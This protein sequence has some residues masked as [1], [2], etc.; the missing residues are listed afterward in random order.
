MGQCL[1]TKTL[2][3]LNMG[4]S[5]EKFGTSPI[6]IRGMSRSGGTLLTSM[7]DAHPNVAMSYELYP[8]LLKISPNDNN[9]FLKIA[10]RIEK[11]DSL[12]S[13]SKEIPVDGFR[14][15]V[16]R[17][18]RSG[19]D[20]WDIAK[21]IKAHIQVG[22]NFSEYTGRLRFIARCCRKKMLRCKKKNWGV[23]CSSQFEKYYKVWPNAGFVNIIRD[24]RDV[25]ASQLNT[26]SFNLSPAEFGKRWAQNHLEF[27]RLMKINNV[28][29]VEVFY[30]RL[31][32]DPESA[33]RNLCNSLNME[34]NSDMVRFHEKDMTLFR[35]PVGH[36]SYTKLI[37]GINDNSI[38]RWKYELS[39]QDL[40][41][42]FKTAGE[43][44]REFDYIK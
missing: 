43:A 40:N 23:K 24:G 31:V 22:D 12:K 39:Y 36:L 9:Y 4:I 13:I 21:L 41:A 1:S 8:N 30:E 35:N 19:I 2:I 20:H 25:L 44:M 18:Y 32:M 7:F 27:R 15:F 33:L 29:G 42:F 37:Q 34:F 17:S 3:I 16:L 6:L 10:K 26:G 38:G 11:L 28:I 14:T 5:E